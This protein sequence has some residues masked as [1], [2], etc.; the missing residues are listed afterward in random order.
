M[1]FSLHRPL[2]VRLVPRELKGVACETRGV[3]IRNR[4]T[5]W[6]NLYYVRVWIMECSLLV[7]DSGE[8]ILPRKSTVSV[9]EYIQNLLC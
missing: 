5:T 6:H 7:F 1:R 3:L 9:P 2:P 8:R 4:E